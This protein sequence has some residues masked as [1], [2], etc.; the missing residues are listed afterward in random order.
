[1]VKIGI[2]SLFFGGGGHKRNLKFEEIINLENLFLAWKEFKQ[3]KSNKKDVQIFQYNLELEIMQLHQELITG[4]YKHGLYHTFYVND[5]KRRHIHKAPVRD[6]IIHHAIVSILALIFERKFIFDSYSCRLR[7]GMHRALERFQKF[8]WKL[9]RNNTKT[10]YILKCDIKK[11]FDNI[12]HQILKDI[13][14]KDIY[15]KRV[16]NL[17]EIVIDSFHK[18]KG[19]ALPLGNVTSQWFANIYLNELDQYVK[20][21]LQVKDYYR[22]G[23]DFILVDRSPQYLY[24]KLVHIKAFLGNNLKLELH[25]SKVKLLKYHNGVDFLGYVQFPH[26]RILRSKTQ[27]RI[28]KAVP[29]LK[30][31]I[32]SLGFKSS[33]ASYM[34]MAQHFASCRFIKKIIFSLFDDRFPT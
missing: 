30:D 15:D 22:Y 20:R 17:L 31:K 27:R 19:R 26:F 29:A 6:R 32:G 4:N 9:S 8:A 21:M 34:G 3:G 14:S 28:L 7:K 24:D 10:V 5:P 1:M 16:M 13:L 2:S 18:E 11:F 25:P 12:D 23:D 33:F